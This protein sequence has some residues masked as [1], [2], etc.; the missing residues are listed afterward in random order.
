M[1]RSFSVLHKRS[2]GV[3]IN[4][5]HHWTYHR[6]PWT[7]QKVARGKW[8]FDYRAVKT[9]KA[10]AMGPKAGSKF[11]WK[12]SA[13]QK[14]TKLGKGKYKTRMIGKKKLLYSKVKK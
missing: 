1:R 11:A 5:R 10:K 2:Y 8:L 14:V 9:Q 13:I 6:G 3:P 4:Y 12:I 7:E